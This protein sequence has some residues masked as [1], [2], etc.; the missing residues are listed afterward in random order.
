M[1][2]SPP[3][4]L[5]IALVG[6]GALALNI[7]IPSMPG[8]TQVFQ[9]DYATIQLALTFYLAATAVAQL[10][11]GTWSDSLGRRPVML[12]G[13]LLF[14]LGSLL[15]TVA[16]TIELLLAARVLQAVGGCVG[17][18][19]GRAMVRDMHD[20]QQAASKIAYITMA[21]VVAPMIAP[22]LG[23]YLDV[24]FDWRASFILV[25]I[26]G[27]CTLLWCLF[28]LPETLRQRRQNQSL[29]AL[30]QDYARLL[31]APLF[32]AWVGVM[33]FSSAIFFGF[34]AGAPYLM[35]NIFERSTEEYGLYFIL[36]S[37]GYMAGNFSTGRLAQRLGSRRMM[38]TG[39]LLGLIGTV[40][41]LLLA[42]LGML[43]PLSLFGSMTIVAFSNGLTIPNSTAASVSVVPDLTGT[44]SGLAGFFQ[45]A[46]GALA[47]II[48]GAFLSSNYISLIYI[49]LACAVLSLLAYLYG[50]SQ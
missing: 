41:N 47:T 30:L 21:M 18:V 38:L 4:A 45:I 49:M 33:A 20:P 10:V 37:V 5:L 16:D 48:V 22:L 42:W 1:P 32:C 7:F 35:V 25:S 19:I 36:V 17:M 15:A 46:I 34:L 50:A 11:L 27:L 12:L 2:K 31:S 9:T 6:L 23:G 13:L 43:S 8:L 40:L 44:A 3:L 26:L 28:A 24:W 29:T 14:I 39:C